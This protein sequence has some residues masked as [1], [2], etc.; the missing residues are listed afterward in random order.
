MF[1]F[2]FQTDTGTVSVI[3]IPGI[4][5]SVEFYTLLF[6]IIFLP[7]ETTTAMKTTKSKMV[8]SSPTKS[9]M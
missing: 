1:S 7:R 2:L 9:K 5:I 4:G 8:R 3:P 6:P